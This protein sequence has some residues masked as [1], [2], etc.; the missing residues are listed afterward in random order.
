[1][2]VKSKAAV[3]I[4]VLLLFLGSLWLREYF[5]V[6]E[7]VCFL[8]CTDNLYN[9]SLVWNAYAP[10]Q[11]CVT[12]CRGHRIKHGGPTT[13]YSLLHVYAQRSF[14]QYHRDI[15]MFDFTCYWNVR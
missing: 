13:F 10:D 11:E 15:S 8:C 14:E 7:C 9:P 1:M 6:C 12:W 2:G 4:L 5:C 3:A